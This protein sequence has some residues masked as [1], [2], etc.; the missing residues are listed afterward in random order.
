MVVP[1]S[2]L[3]TGESNREAIV[4][5]KVQTS[6]HLLDKPLCQQAKDL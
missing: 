6:E 3:P 1:G 4:F 5:Q 2:I